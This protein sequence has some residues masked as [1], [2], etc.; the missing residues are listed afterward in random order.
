MAALF[1]DSLILSVR[2]PIDLTSRFLNI[3]LVTPSGPDADL[4][5]SAKM[6]YL[7]SATEKTSSSSSVPAIYRTHLEPPSCRHGTYSLCLGTPRANSF[8]IHYHWSLHQCNSTRHLEPWKVLWNIAEPLFDEYGR[9]LQSRDFNPS[10]EPYFKAPSQRA[11]L[12]TQ[13]GRLSGHFKLE[14]PILRLHNIQVKALNIHVTGVVT[15]LTRLLRCLITPLTTT[16]ISGVITAV[17]DIVTL[18]LR[19][20]GLGSFLSFLQGALTPLC[21]LSGTTTI[22]GCTTLLTGNQTCSAPISITFPDTLNL[23]RCLNQTLLLCQNGAIATDGLLINVINTVTCL[24]TS[25]LTTNP[26][27]SINGLVCLIAGLLQ[28]VPGLNFLG[29]FLRLTFGCS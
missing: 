4:R 6:G 12:R 13:S 9:A 3:P 18:V 2:K 28:A 21:A 1:Q 20:I 15:A 26:G 22:P 16:S 29:F 19:T 14:T 25:L 24:L 5:L 27:T 11:R 7:T 10:P 17:A 8:C 23:S